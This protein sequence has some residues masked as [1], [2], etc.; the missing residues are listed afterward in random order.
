MNFKKTS[1]L[2]ESVDVERKEFTRPSE[3]ITSNA[4][5]IL[6]YVKKCGSI[7]ES[8]L[9]IF[10]NGLSET[11]TNTP[12]GWVYENS[13]YFQRTKNGQNYF[14]SLNELGNKVL[15]ESSATED[16]YIDIIGEGALAT[17]KRKYTDLHPA[18]TA[19]IAT[20]VRNKVLAH[21]AES[22]KI[23]RSAFIAYIKQ[24]NEESGRKTTFA[25]VRQNAHL[26]KVTEDKETK[27]KFFELSAFGV[28]VLN[29][30]TINENV[31]L[32]EILLEDYSDSLIKAIAKQ[33][34]IDVAA[35]NMDQLKIGMEVVLLANGSAAGE[36]ADVTG[37]DPIQTLRIV[38]GN[39]K[40]D[41]EFYT[42]AKP[43]NWGAE[44][45]KAAAESEP[46]SIDTTAEQP[47]AG[48]DGETTSDIKVPG[49]DPAGSDQTAT[50]NTGDTSTEKP[51]DGEP[52]AEKPV[53]TNTDVEGTDADKAP[54]PDA[55]DKTVPKTDDETKADK[56][57][58]PINTDD[59]GTKAPDVKVDDTDPANADVAKPKTGEPDQIP[60]GVSDRKSIADIANKHSVSEDGIF[61]E[62]EV[63]KK[64]EIEHTD[65]I[66]KA[67]EIARD[68]LW[69]DPKYYSKLVADGLSDEEDAIKLAKELLGV[70]P[71][72]K[73]AAEP[74]KP[75]EEP[76]KPAEST[77][78]DEEVKPT[79]TADAPKVEEPKEEPKE[80]DDKKLL[81]DEQKA[82][83]KQ[84]IADAGAVTIGDEEI[85]RL[86]K[87]WEISFDD[88]KSY[89]E[90]LSVEKEGEKGDG[91]KSNESVAEMSDIMELGE[92]YKFPNGIGTILSVSEGAY[93]VEF[94]TG[95][96]TIKIET[97]INE[98]D[99][100]TVSNVP[101]M[102]N[103]YLP[104]PGL[105]GSG[106]KFDD[107]QLPANAGLNRSGASRF[108]MKRLYT[109]D[110][111][112]KNSL[113][114]S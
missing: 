4:N 82:E 56:S 77:V 37:N 22:G 29:R 70:E 61:K 63:G 42:K 16:V 57:V 88:L 40:R 99:A 32:E 98:T 71:K 18:K 106:D 59:T 28:R 65:D 89:I 111:F 102:G 110:D 48:T 67:A 94:E 25:W 105:T 103:V 91:D 72:A 114:E 19:Q 35:Y 47:A 30:T 112:I 93:L 7:A 79:P 1:R 104:G 38:I 100:S 26:F 62:L 113:Q 52:A 3:L 20:P 6:A 87:E 13:K 14:V 10:I 8:T 49:L 34:G 5:A 80:D 74:A 2:N 15:A 43:D 81:T 55:D 90:L 92:K 64:V 31:S 58:E 21:I 73:P 69:E 107:D 68:H 23:E 85:T 51:V 50:D 66:K 76:A 41:S 97:K 83:L 46:T 17:V 27:Q 24:M 109:L 78:K 86:S 12:L 45:F 108:N 95:V 9:S 11:T 44:F 36:D 53:D 54:A 33:Q 60:G 75:V 96:S 39:L 84:L 101:G